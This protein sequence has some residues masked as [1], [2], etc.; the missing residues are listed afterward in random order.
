MKEKNLQEAAEWIA[1]AIP[2]S[3]E[4]EKDFE[5]A[6]RRVRKLVKAELT[7]EKAHEEGVIDAYAMMAVRMDSEVDEGQSWTG[8]FVGGATLRQ[9][10]LMLACSAVQANSY[11]KKSIEVFLEKVH[12]FAE[13]MIVNEKKSWRKVH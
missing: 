10:A 12:E 11:D 5:E 6:L 4:P 13:N 1:S 9:L 3:L 7:L 2:P 8:S